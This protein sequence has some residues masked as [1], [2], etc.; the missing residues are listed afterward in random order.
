MLKK[1]PTAAKIV[2]VVPVAAAVA[3]LVLVCV[4][5]LLPKES[6]VPVTTN[7]ET[8]EAE[9]TDALTVEYKYSNGTYNGTDTGFGGPVTLAVTI[10]EDKIESIEVVESSDDEPFWTNA[11]ALADTILSTQ[12]TEVDT[13]TGAK[14]V[15]SATNFNV[16]ETV[17]DASAELQTGSTWGDYQINVTENSTALIRNNRSD[18][19]WAVNA[20]VQGIIL[21]T[22][23][24]LKVGMEYL[25]SIWVQPWEVS[26]N[27]TEES[28]NNSHIAVWDNLPEL[29]KLVGEDV[30]RQRCC[31]KRQRSHRTLRRSGRT[32]CRQRY[33]LYRSR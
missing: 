28:T 25:Q 20:N 17:T 1:N 4:P 10:T 8:S 3:L 29:A 30:H 33:D 11:L 9:E 26:F 14:A 24:G 12:S 6:E 15:Y 31:S 5:S 16:E 27:V 2:P 18:E 13:I 21:E 23:S 7:A 32:S 19:G 22:E